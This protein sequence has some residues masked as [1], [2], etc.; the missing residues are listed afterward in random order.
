MRQELAFA[1]I[2]QGDIS[3]AD[4]W[5]LLL[6]ILDGAD[7]AVAGRL[8]DALRAWAWKAIDR[9]RRDPG[10]REWIDLLNRV[11][12]FFSSKFEQLAAK[13]ELLSEMIHESISVADL[14]EP[15][16]VLK[17]KHVFDVLC[18]LN[19][20]SGDWLERAQLMNYLDLKPAN[21]TRLMSQLVD[22]GWVDQK[23]EG[24]EALYRLSVE[25][26]RQAPVFGF[27]QYCGLEVYASDDGE[28]QSV[29]ENVGSSI[30]QN[31][32]SSSSYKW[33]PTK[34][35]KLIVS[36]PM[37][38]MSPVNHTGMAFPSSLVLEDA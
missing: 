31:S 30:N 23:V 16:D 36:N 8:V 27:D 10:L 21:T 20:S 32:R 14:M 6:P 2:R 13:I 34:S 12:S 29:I 19:S 33:A 9:R 26:V 37:H 7:Q 18:V 11:E 24:R 38:K 5:K 4:G 15:E 22:L 25:G 3:A 17:R 35:T 28:L 1:S